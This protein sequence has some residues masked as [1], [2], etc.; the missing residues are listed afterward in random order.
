[1]HLSPDCTD[2]WFQR[3]FKTWFFLCQRTSNRDCICQ[4]NVMQPTPLRKMLNYDL[5]LEWTI[6]TLCFQWFNCI[7][8]VGGFAFATAASAA[9][10]YPIMGASNKCFAPRGTV[11]P[12]NGHVFRLCVCV[13]VYMMCLITLRYRIK[14]LQPLTNISAV[15]TLT[16]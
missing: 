16:N 9:G 5:L 4:F 14:L 11:I 6:F 7:S 8:F 13:C 3:H 2:D 12:S 1:M 10:Y 15:W